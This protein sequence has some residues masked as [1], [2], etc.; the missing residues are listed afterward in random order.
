MLKRISEIRVPYLMIPF[1]GIITTL[2]TD[3]RTSSYISFKIKYVDL[4]RNVLWKKKLM[5]QI[6]GKDSTTSYTKDEKN[7]RN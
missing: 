4:E 3:S 1:A 6:S 7:K 5:K 2:L